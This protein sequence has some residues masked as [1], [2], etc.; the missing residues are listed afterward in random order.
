MIRYGTFRSN[1][2]RFRRQDFHAKSLRLHHRAPRQIAA[3]E[4]R[5]KAE[6]IFDARAHARLAARR[7]PLDHHRVQ[8]F[9]RSVHGGGEACRPSADDRQIVEAC[10]RARPQADFLRDL[11]RGAFEELRPIGKEDDWKTCRFRSE[12][13][14]KKFGLRIARGNLRVDPLVGDV[15]AREEVAQ[16]IRPGRPSRAEY[17]NSRIGWMVGSLPVAEQIVQ[18]RI[19]VLGG[20]VPR[21]HE[22]IVDAGLIDGANR[23][24]RVRVCGE[25]RALGLRVNP[26]GFL[27]EVHAV[28]ARHALVRQEQGHAVAAEF[29]LLQKVERALR[30]IRFPGRDNPRRTATASRVQSLAKHPRRRPRSVRLVSPWSVPVR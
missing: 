6:I 26:H 8:A 9:R 27:Q 17:A 15:I 29:Q 2:G 12:S 5:R 18:L 23:G 22:K 28:D 19:E 21:L 24:G 20:R 30:A 13:F 11:R 1:F 10:L 4:P 3:A 14:Q 7:F 16:F 25:Q